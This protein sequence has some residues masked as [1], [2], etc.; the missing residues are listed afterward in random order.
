MECETHKVLKRSGKNEGNNT[1]LDTLEREG[2]LENRLKQPE[3]SKK[4]R[5]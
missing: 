3:Y 1:D 5:K 4:V 2:Q